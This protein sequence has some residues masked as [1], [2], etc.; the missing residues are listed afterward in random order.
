MI[1]PRITVV[2]TNRNYGRYLPQAITSVLNQGYPNLEY[3][4]LDAGSTDDSVEVIQRYADRLAY[5][6]SCLDGGPA[7]ALNTGLQRA[8]GEWFY[9]LNS[10]DY[11]LPGAL[12]TFA[13][14][15]AAAGS[16]LW[17]SGGR[18]EVD[19]QGSLLR[20]R[21]PWRED[22][23]LFAVRQMWHAAEGTFLHLPS[24][25]RLGLTFNEAYQNIFDT[26]LYTRLDRLEPPLYVDTLFAA[27]RLH[28]ANMSGTTNAAAVAR[29]AAA[30]AKECPPPTIFQRAA[31]R[32]SR[33]RFRGASERFLRVLFHAG[34]AGRRPRLSAALP[35]GHES[36]AE[37]PLRDALRLP[38]HR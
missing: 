23:H 21:V 2:T 10:D 37:V 25:R 5:W 28:G 7:S 34:V 19:A 4:V 26:V 1:T 14:I 3:M 27:M 11:L 16:R 36:F 13:A 38:A 30:H 33:T 15:V 8:T 17:I 20:T 9:Y 22:T 12:K 24:L 32:A 35:D 29:D 18:Q 31:S 6:H